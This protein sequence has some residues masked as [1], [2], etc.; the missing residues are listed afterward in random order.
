MTP[1]NPPGASVS[2]TASQAAGSSS[3]GVPIASAQNTPQTPATNAVQAPVPQQGVGGGAVVQSLAGAAASG[4]TS[5][6]RARRQPPAAASVPLT[7]RQRGILFSMLE[8]SGNPRAMAVLNPAKS[9][10]GNALLK[11]LPV[12]LILIGD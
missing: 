1:I 2:S 6:G 11:P 5:Q 10:A 7:S 8:I 4:G 12:Y 9:V 3:Q